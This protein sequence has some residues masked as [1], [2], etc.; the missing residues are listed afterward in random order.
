MLNKWNKFNFKSLKKR[1]YINKINCNSKIYLIKILVNLN[2]KKNLAVSVFSLLKFSSQLPYIIQIKT[3]TNFHWIILTHIR[4]KHIML[5]LINY[6]IGLL[7]TIKK[8]NWVNIINFKN[9]RYI[10]NFYISNITIFTYL[11]INFNN[12]ND[13]FK[14]QFSIYYISNQQKFIFIYLNLK[15]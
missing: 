9:N 8:D 2:N 7:S 6:K 15:S 10:F 12:M 11:N 1:S 3:I 14:Y 4:G 13:I 5:L